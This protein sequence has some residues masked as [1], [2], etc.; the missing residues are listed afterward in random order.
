[1]SI[2]PSA[3]QQSRPDLTTILKNSDGSTIDVGGLI[4]KNL[5]NDNPN[6]QQAGESIAGGLPA[7]ALQK[8]SSI[9]LRSF[10]GVIVTHIEILKEIL[11]ESVERDKDM[12]ESIEQLHKL[13]CAMQGWTSEMESRSLRTSK[14]LLESNAN[15]EKRVADLETQIAEMASAIKPSKPNS[16]SKAEPSGIN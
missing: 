9:E 1:M 4:K 2:D 16:Q 5:K 15:L 14:N 12:N 3:K 10:V 13:S 11:K 8:M 6:Y 7:D